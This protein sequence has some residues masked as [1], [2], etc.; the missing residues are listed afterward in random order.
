MKFYHYRILYIYVTSVT[1]LMYNQL[2]QIFMY[3]CMYIYYLSIKMKLLP[4]DYIYI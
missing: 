2:L 4:K 1:R 3:M